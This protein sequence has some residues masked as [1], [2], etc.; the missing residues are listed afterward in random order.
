[1][2]ANYIYSEIKAL[3][4]VVQHVQYFTSNLLQ[5]VPLNTF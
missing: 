2:K 3:S 1:M 4:F 5:I